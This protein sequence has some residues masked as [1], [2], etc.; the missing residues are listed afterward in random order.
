MK[1]KLRKLRSFFMDESGQGMVEYILIIGLI[2]LFILVVLL[3]FRNAISTMLQKV[4]AVVKGQ[5]GTIK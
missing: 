5:T 4:I 1:E 3:V 2:V